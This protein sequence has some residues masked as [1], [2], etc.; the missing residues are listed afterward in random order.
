LVGPSE[1]T[2]LSAD[3]LTVVA[4]R[5]GAAGRAKASTASAA[6]GALFS[7]DRTVARDFRVDRGEFGPERSGAERGEQVLHAGDSG[8]AEHD[9]EEHAGGADD[10]A[11]DHHGDVLEQHAKR[12]D[13]GAEGRQCV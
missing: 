5:A 10:R 6:R 13:H 2:K 12:D 11:D 3:A 1:A 4:A 7:T 9:L 8:L